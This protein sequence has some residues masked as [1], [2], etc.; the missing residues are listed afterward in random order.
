MRKKVVQGVGFSLVCVSLI[1]ITGCG[2]GY[3]A[4]EKL[5]APTPILDNSGKYMCPYRQDGT[6]ADW[7]SKALAKVLGAEA[8]KRAGWM[9]GAELLGGAA[10]IGK[11][12]GEKAGGALALEAAGGMEGIRQSSDISFNTWEDLAVYMYVNY[13]LR[14]DY[15][16]TLSVMY[17]IWPEFK[18]KYKMALAKASSAVK[19]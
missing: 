17:D 15:K 1:F 16:N 5:T 8:G 13:S 14:E 12:V 9:L 18:N 4:P 11:K 6:Q 7:S 10:G 19:Q 3:A 2:G